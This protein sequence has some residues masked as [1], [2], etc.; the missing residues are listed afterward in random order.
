MELEPRRQSPQ[1]EQQA[2]DCG[3]C[4]DDWQVYQQPTEVPYYDKEDHF[5]RSRHNDNGQHDKH[6]ERDD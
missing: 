1:E 5:E 6:Q 2:Q 4:E 3:G